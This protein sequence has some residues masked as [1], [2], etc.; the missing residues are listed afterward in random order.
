MIMIV[1][2]R[3]EKHSHKYLLQR[4]LNIKYGTKCLS[5]Q[6]FSRL[7]SILED[8]RI[9]NEENVRLYLQSDE[10]AI[11]PLLIDLFDLIN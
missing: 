5:D 10:A 3:Y 8:L 2:D 1:N 4:Y 11:G 7:M 9:L 6:K